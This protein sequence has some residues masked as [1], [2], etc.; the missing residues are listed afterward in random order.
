MLLTLTALTAF[1]SPSA[2]P[3]SI[4]RPSATS[5]VDH[6]CSLMATSAPEPSLL[7]AIFLNNNQRTVY[8][9]TQPTRS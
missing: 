5:S 7:R 4:I 8:P 2:H 6:S 9:L 1:C 3:L